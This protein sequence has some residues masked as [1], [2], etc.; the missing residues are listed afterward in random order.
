M[1]SDISECSEKLESRLTNHILTNN[2]GATINIVEYTS[3][4]T[5]DIIGRVGFGHDFKAEVP[6]LQTPSGD[7]QAPLS[8]ARAIRIAWDHLVETGLEP[9]S[10]IAPIVV[11]AFPP[12]T[13]APLP[14]MRAQGETKMV[15]KRLAGRYVF[16]FATVWFTHSFLP[17]CSSVRKNLLLPVLPPRSKVVT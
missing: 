11:R 5:L 2:G 15:V 10:F 13:R 4:V 16:V 3:A 6:S 1:S 12:I 14:L 8:D 7:P 9:T 17:V